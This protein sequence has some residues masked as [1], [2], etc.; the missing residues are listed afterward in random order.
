MDLMETLLLHTISV[1]QLGAY[2]E[3]G[4]AKMAGWARVPDTATCISGAA[5]SSPLPRFAAQYVHMY[6]C[7]HGVPVQASPSFWIALGWFIGV[8]NDMRFLRVR[9]VGEDSICRSRLVR[10]SGAKP[11]PLLRTPMAYK[12]EYKK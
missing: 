12:R 11:A 6:V 1:S 9:V 3:P 10:C 2:L 7:L 4:T 5:L 8:S